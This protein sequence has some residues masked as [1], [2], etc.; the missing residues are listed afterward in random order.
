MIMI[1]KLQNLR[2]ENRI[3]KKA[4]KSGETFQ[5]FLRD[6]IIHDLTVDCLAR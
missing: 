2:K 3:A 5:T 4:R 1:K 6:F